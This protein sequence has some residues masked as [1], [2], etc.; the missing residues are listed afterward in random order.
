MCIRDSFSVGYFNGTSGNLQED[1]LN[2]LEDVRENLQDIND[3]DHARTASGKLGDSLR[4]LDDAGQTPA[5]VTAIRAKYSNPNA[6]LSIGGNLIGDL[7]AQTI[8]D[9]S[10]IRQNAFGR[11]VR[12]CSET[13]GRVW[14]QLVDDPNQIQAQ[15]RL[16]A[17][18]AS[19]AFVQQGKV[20]LLYTS[21]A[22]D[23]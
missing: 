23:E 2:R 3:P 17:S 7:V 4:W 22:A 15:L 6:Y 12:G 21:D 11:L 1:M 19:G 8:S 10:P 16:D 5:L 9:R 20:C 18:V 13:N 14:L